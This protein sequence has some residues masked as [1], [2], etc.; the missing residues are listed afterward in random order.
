MDSKRPKVEASFPLESYR[1][2]SKASLIFVSRAKD[3]TLQFYR[4][5][6][7]S[8]RPR[9]SDVMLGSSVSSRRSLGNVWP[10][11][12]VQVRIGNWPSGVYFA[13][14]TAR[15]GRVGYAP[16]VLRPRRLGEQRVAVV[17][18]TQTWQAYNFRDENGDHVGDTWY[19][20]WH[21]NT[22]RM[23]RA[24]L[25]RGVPPHYKY[26]DE[27]FLHWL[28]A[29]GK[30]VD[31]LSDAELNHVSSGAALARDYVL[32]VFPGHHEY[33]TGHEFDVVTGFR[34]HGGNLMFLSANN[35]FWKVRRHGDLMTR[36]VRFR[37]IGRSEAR[38]V[39]VEYFDWEHG[40]HGRGPWVVRDDKA[41]SWIF[42]GTG[43][44]R[45]SHFG[46]GG[47]EADSTCPYS[48]RNIHVLATIPNIFRTGRAA[49]MTYYQRN[50]ATVFAAG[51]FTLSGSVW[52]PPVKRMIENLWTRLGSA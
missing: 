24:F 44:A 33:V 40:T 5:G 37:D 38:L 22:V 1:P 20:D 32:I 26:Y 45:G 27:P 29:S 4:A 18:P 3:V 19:G 23:G 51:A 35:F 39:G 31:Y 48:P 11:R 8:K 14:F 7:E 42:D 47:I 41:A 49:Q 12:T 34:N 2:G 13:R 28:H 43:L 52:Q 21:R 6:T 36:V 9:A 16:F 15:G 10:R 25:N 46:S 50:G 17:M 30:S